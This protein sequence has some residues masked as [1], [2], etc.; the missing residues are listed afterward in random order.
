[1][2]IVFMTPET[3][4]YARVGGLAEFSHDLPLALARMGHTVDVI[5]LRCREGLELCKDL[6]RLDF[7]LEIPV[8]WRTQQAVFY[9]HKPHERVN[10]YLI[11]NDHYYERDGLYGNAFGDYE[12]NAERFIFFSRAALEL[13]IAL[14]KS[15]DI[16]HCNDWT[17]ALVPLYL[18]TLYK[19]VEIFKNAASLLTIH[20]VQ[21][22]GVFWHYDMPLTGLDWEYFNQDVLEFHGKINFLKAGIFF[23]DFISTVSH[24][25]AREILTP[26]VAR[27]L[28]GV[29]L[30][31]FSRLSAIING[32]DNDTWNPAVDP[33]IKA[34]YTADDLK[35]KKECKKELIREFK[36]SGEGDRPLM[37]FV[38]RL[39]DRRGLAILLPG[40]EKIIDMGADL[41]IMG[42]GEDHYH[43]SLAHFQSKQNGRLGLYVGYDMALAHKVMAGAD[44]LIMPSK[45]EPCG[46]HQLHAMRYGTAPIVRAVGGLDDTIRD[47]SS[48]NPGVGF[49]F[50]D[51]T[52]NDMLRAVQ[53]A[54][55]TYAETNEW[56]A[57]VGRAMTRSYTW[58]QAA[59]RYVELYERARRLGESRQEA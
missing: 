20:N 8:S 30:E 34:Q 2:H 19:E 21:S 45:S 46:L 44:M 47:H 52:T 17:T 28:E 23:A 14:E 6:S 26:Q 37:A 7:E 53:R 59:P 40:L 33:H 31:R 48:T 22:Q 5:T 38:G 56:Q 41:V 24:R 54:L 25:Y 11:A 58:E 13:L 16:I 42:F 29:I 18:K 32:V 49:K 43:T 3:W 9:H 35:G 12:D 57:L 4:P 50:E 55:D 1:M 39:L 15:P 27:G 51:Y 10:V 36:L